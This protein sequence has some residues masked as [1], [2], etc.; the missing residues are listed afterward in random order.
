MKMSAVSGCF[1]E[2]TAVKVRVQRGY[3]EIAIAIAA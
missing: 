3:Q 2:T 1:S